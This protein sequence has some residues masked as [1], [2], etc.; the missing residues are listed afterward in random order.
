MPHDLKLSQL[1]L[2]NTTLFLFLFGQEPAEIDGRA[3]EGYKK[4]AP[5]RCTVYKW[6]S[7]FT[8]DNYSIEDEDRPR[9]SMELDLDGLRS[10]SKPIRIKLLMNWQ[11]LLGIQ[12]TV[13]RGLK[14]IGKVRKLGRWVPHA[15][16]LKRRN[17]SGVFIS[18][19]SEE[20]FILHPTMPRASIF[21][22]SF[23][24]YDL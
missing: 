24:S 17:G 8:S 11:S 19:Y 9:R 20:L 5:A 21:V 7:K 6:H 3:K 18:M 15:L 10:L 13:I 14:Q 16:T 1:H 23:P 2:H 12:S 22:T 4:V